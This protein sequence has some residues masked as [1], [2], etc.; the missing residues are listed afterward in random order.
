MAFISEIIVCRIIKRNPEL[1]DERNGILKSQL[2]DGPT[3]ACS[4]VQGLQPLLYL[5]VVY[6]HSNTLYCMLIRD[7]GVQKRNE[8][9]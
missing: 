1:R 9:C 7:N 6:F 3:F 8:D 2:T 4:G 5:L